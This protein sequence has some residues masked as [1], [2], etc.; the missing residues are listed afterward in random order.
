MK[1]S[2]RKLE[3]EGIDTIGGLIFNRLGALPKTG[4][5]VEIDG[6]K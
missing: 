4:R 1:C 2:R 6:L 3:Q 5:A